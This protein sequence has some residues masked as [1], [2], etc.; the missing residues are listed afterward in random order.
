MIADAM[1][2]TGT[3]KFDSSKADGQFKKTANNG[4]LRSLLPDYKFVSMKEGISQSV[5]WFLEHYDEARK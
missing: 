5:Q 3:V 4:K 1:G 2:F